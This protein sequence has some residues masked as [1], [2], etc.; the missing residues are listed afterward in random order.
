MWF[1]HFRHGQHA[2]NMNRYTNDGL[3][4]IHFIFRIAKGNGCV[5]VRLY[6]EYIQQGGNRIIKRLLGFNKT[7]RN[8]DLSVPRLTTRPSTVKWTW[9]HEYQSQ[10]L[11]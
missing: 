5:D 2:M 8:M 6:A 3:A 10:L 1:P 11:R 4:D 9:W 7:W